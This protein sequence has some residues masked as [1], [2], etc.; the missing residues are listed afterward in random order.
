MKNAALIAPLIAPLMAAASLIDLMM[1]S[2][3]RNPLQHHP[4]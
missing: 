3:I 1:F 4:Q 2:G